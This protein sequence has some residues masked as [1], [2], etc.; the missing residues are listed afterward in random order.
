MGD[1]GVKESCR[2]I[3]SSGYLHGSCYRFLTVLLCISEALVI[4]WFI[5]HPQLQD[6]KLVQKDLQSK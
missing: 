3:I 1:R 5:K 2:V 4:H 6:Q